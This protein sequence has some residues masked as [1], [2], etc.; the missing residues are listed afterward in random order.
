MIADGGT[1]SG[2]RFRRSVLRLRRLE[3]PNAEISV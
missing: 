3:F 1:Q 2:L